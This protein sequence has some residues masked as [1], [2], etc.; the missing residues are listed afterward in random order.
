MLKDHKSAAAAT[1]DN[2]KTGVKKATALSL[3]EELSKSLRDGLVSPSWSDS[4]CQ[5][6]MNIDTLGCFPI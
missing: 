6:G 4:D 2:S 1:S 5:I 3:E